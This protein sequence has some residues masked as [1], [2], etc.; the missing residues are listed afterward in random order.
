MK[1]LS[2]AEPIM[3]QWQ[4]AP[5]SILRMVL[6][7]GPP[8]VGKTTVAANLSRQCP[9]QNAFLDGDDLAMTFPGGTDRKRLD[10][11]ERNIVHCADGYREWGAQYCFCSWIVA[12]QH[13]LDMLEKK[14]RARKVHLRFIALD[15]PVDVLVDRMMNRSDTRFSPTGENL[16]YLSGLRKRIRNLEHCEVLDT[17]GRHFTDVS[18]E[19]AGLIKAPNFWTR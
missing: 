17:T 14:M 11:I 5:K 10:L 1:F 2:Q 7:I 6:L 16:A 18:N 13:R 4:P 3:D 9:H 12:H 8:G 15:A 19:A